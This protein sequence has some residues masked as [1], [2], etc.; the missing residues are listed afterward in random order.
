MW[1]SGDAIIISTHLLAASLS[2]A[3]VHLSG[4]LHVSPRPHQNNRRIN[5]LA[6]DARLFMLNAEKNP[7]EASRIA[8]ESAKRV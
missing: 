8:A 7:S 5:P 3:M 2:I 6:M 1:S 4:N